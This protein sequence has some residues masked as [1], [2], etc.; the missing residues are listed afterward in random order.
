MNL[1]KKDVKAWKHLSTGKIILKLYKID[2]NQTQS[3]IMKAVCSTV[4]TTC[5]NNLVA[6]SLLNNIVET[7]LNNIVETM[8]NNVVEIRMN[9]I[10][11]VQQCCSHMIT[12][13]FKHC[14]GNYPNYPTILMIST[15]P[16]TL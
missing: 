14:S 9:N 10:L 12:M 2:I 5:M 15:T 4:P 1:L 16:T 13:L 11:S 7:M 6:S 8:L 3:W